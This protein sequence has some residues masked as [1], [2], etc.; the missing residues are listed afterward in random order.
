MYWNSC[1]KIYS[2]HRTGAVFGRAYQ[3]VQVDALSYGALCYYFEYIG[4]G[5]NLYKMRRNVVCFYII[6]GRVFQTV[7]QSLWCYTSQSTAGWPCK[8]CAQVP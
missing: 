6:L 2:H 7:V 1:Y 8:A 3:Y 4:E 5:I